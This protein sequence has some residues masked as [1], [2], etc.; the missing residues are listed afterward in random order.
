MISDERLLEELG[1]IRQLEATSVD[2][3]AVLARAHTP[4]RSRRSPM[5]ALAIG[6]LAVLTALALTPG[7]R[8][9]LAGVIDAFF[10]DQIP[11]HAVNGQALHG[12]QVPRWLRPDLHRALLVAG[13]GNDRLI[14]YRQD[15]AYCFDY[16]GSVDEC[17]SAREWS[18]EL[19]QHPV[20][21]RGPTGGVGHPRGAVYGF[22]R[23]DVTA[24]RLSC[25]THPPISASARNGGFAI[26]T[27]ARWQPQQLTLLGHH[28]WV[29]ATVNIA[30]RA[31]AGR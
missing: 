13:S 14:A 8:S 22:T 30:N 16:G 26:P 23:G 20:V 9:A 4:T 18:R 25:A 29:I 21:L 7:A 15:R 17:A 5:L 19:A 3:D 11:N 28:G 24:V 31:S 2:V 10:G 27:D 6:V 1:G 12:L